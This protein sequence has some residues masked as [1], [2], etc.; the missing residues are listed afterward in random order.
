MPVSQTVAS[1]FHFQYTQYNVETALLPQDCVN[2]IMTFVHDHYLKL[3]KSRMVMFCTEYHQRVSVHDS[4][5]KLFMLIYSDSFGKCW[6]TL[7]S[8]YKKSIE[9]YSSAK[10]EWESKIVAIADQCESSH[11]G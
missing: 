7:L 2:C 8:P 10:L 1:N 3:W 6:I 9:Y 4:P 5:F 11:H